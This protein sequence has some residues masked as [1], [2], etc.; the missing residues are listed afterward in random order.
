[1][2]IHQG[3]RPIATSVKKTKGKKISLSF[4]KISIQLIWL[5]KI[6]YQ[7]SIDYVE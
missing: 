3:T 1:M 2:A 5:T 4:V 7:N 6:P